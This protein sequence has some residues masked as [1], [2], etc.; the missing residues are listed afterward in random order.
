MTVPGGSTVCDGMMARAPGSHPLDAIRAIGGI[1]S[2]TVTDVEV[3]DAQRLAFEKLKLVVEP[4]GA[5]GIAALLAQTESVVGRT[6]LVIVTGGNTSFQGLSAAFADERRQS[7]D[8]GES[9]RSSD[10]RRP[11]S[12]SLGD[13]TPRGR[14]IEQEQP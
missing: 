11:F 9:V 8:L 7:E 3:R 13:R 4:S 1:G 10:R 14:R 12:S 5:S 2:A 6:V